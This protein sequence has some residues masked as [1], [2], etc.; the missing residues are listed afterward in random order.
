MMIPEY[1]RF[2]GGDVQTTLDMLARTFFAM[3]NAM[4]SIKA[5]ELLDL[6]YMTNNAFAGDKSS[7]Y[8]EALKKQIKGIAGI[9][10]EVRIVKK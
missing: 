9:V 10:E 2:Y 5:R 1:I 8:E 6:L 7:S 3:L 4:Y